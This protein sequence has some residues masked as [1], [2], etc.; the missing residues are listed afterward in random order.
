MA[1]EQK[2]EEAATKKRAHK[3]SYAKDK[4]NGGYII[5]VEGPNANAFA[6]REVPVTMKDGDEHQE[7]LLSL[8]W[9]GKDM[10]SGKPVALYSFEAKPKDE[11]VDVAF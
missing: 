7:K 6:G 5:R 9:A 3:A 1:G 10:E 11:E 4:K 8:I 2:K